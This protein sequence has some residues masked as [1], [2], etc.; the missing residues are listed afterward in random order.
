MAARTRSVK[1]RG[2]IDGALSAFAAEFADL[3]DIINDWE[4]LPETATAGREIDW[5]NDMARLDRLHQAYCAG[6]MTPAQAERY[7]KVIALLKEHLSLVRRVR[8][9]EPPFRLEEVA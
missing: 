2:W 8:W 6:A 4:T 1:S 3:P 7:R 5:D 9:A